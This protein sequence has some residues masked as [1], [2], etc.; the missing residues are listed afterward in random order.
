M[1]R[2]S[3]SQPRIMVQY[4]AE[5]TNVLLLTRVKLWWEKIQERGETKVASTCTNSPGFAQV[6]D[7]LENP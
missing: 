1:S 5:K 4:Y 2:T 3:F 6:F 7:N